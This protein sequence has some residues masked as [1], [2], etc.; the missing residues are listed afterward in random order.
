MNSFKVLIL[1]KGTLKY[2]AY[3]LEVLCGNTL[4]YRWQN[5]FFV[6]IDGIAVEIG[7]KVDSV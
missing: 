1:R 5:P 6:A 7:W 2:H 4:F 3:K